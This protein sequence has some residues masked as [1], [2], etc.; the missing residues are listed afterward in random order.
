MSHLMN[1]EALKQELS[2]LLISSD[3][4]RT[5]QGLPSGLI[6]LDG[7][8]E[9]QGLPRGEMSLLISPPGS[10][11]TSFCLQLLRLNLP[12]LGYAAWVSSKSHL[13]APHVARTHLD[14]KKIL[15]VRRP[16]KA[17]SFFWILEEVLAT[18]T[19]GCVICHLETNPLSNKQFIK[20]KRIARQ[21]NICL[22]FLVSADLL[23]SIDEFAVVMKFSFRQLLVLRA[24]HRPTPFLIEM[25]P[26]PQLMVQSRTGDFDGSALPAPRK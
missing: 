23:G 12:D 1:L 2:S 7:F 17:R 22:I 14:L 20:L 13:F 24:L 15:L 25:H 9:T 26:F 19:F 6:A 10:G 5:P 16:E 4:I 11:G 3:R 18:E 8:L 21:K